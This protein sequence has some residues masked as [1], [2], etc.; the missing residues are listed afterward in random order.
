[1]IGKGGVC[2]RPVADPWEYPAETPSPLAGWRKT[3]WPVCAA[4]RFV[5]SLAQPGGTWRSVPGSTAYLEAKAQGDSSMPLKQWPPEA[6]VGAALQDPRD[7]VKATLPATQSPVGNDGCP[8][9]R[10]L[11]PMSRHAQTSIG[12]QGNLHDAKRR[13]TRTDKGMSG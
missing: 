10:R 3:P 4:R 6:S 9:E 11:K 2:A 13:P 1:M 5:V 12:G 8:S 7:M